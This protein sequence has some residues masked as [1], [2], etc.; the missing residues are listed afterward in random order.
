MDVIYESPLSVNFTLL[1]SRNFLILIVIYPTHEAK[2][3]N[4]KAAHPWD[5]HHYAGAEG[6][7]GVAFVC[8]DLEEFAASIWNIYAL[9]QTALSTKWGQNWTGTSFESKFRL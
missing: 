9:A 2:L 4:L 8:V 5:Q 7:R 1:R 6:K 3:M